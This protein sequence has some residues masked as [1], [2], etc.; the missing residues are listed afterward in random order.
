MTISELGTLACAGT[1]LI[2]DALGRLDAVQGLAR[3]D[4]W[5][6]TLVGPAFTV[7][8]REGDN[9]A[10]LH[11]LSVANRGDVLVVD[12]GGALH[13]A[14][15]GDLAR[16][17][18]ISRGI[19]GFVIEGA[20]RDVSAFHTEEPFGCFARGT[21]HRG[22]FKDGPGRLNVPVAIGGQVVNPGDIIVADN[23]GIVSFAPDRLPW[24]LRATGDRA[25]AEA[26]IREQISSG[27]QSQAWLE[28]L[29]A[30]AGAKIS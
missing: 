30:D 6:G 10:L 20:I 28:A 18:A 29:R 27:E 17:F 22:P 13:R 15:A 21:S 5:R 4:G 19:A 24:L 12:G 16:S 25:A 1:P 14:L 2:S 9:L 3:F 7:K 11:A 8:T 26:G 23:D